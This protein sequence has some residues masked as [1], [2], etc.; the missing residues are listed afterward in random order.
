MNKKIIGAAFGVVFFAVVGAQGQTHPPVRSHRPVRQSASIQPSPLTPEME[1]RLNQIGKLDEAAAA[2]LDVGQYAKAEGYA[3]QSVSL[4]VASG[5]GQEFLAA[6]LDAQGKTQ[7]AL[8]VY[9]SIADEGDVFP[10][11]QLPYA[12]LLLKTG[13][14]EQAVAAY[15]RQ[16]PYLASGN[17]MLANSRF[18]PAVPQPRELEVAIHI[19]LGLTEGWRGYHWKSGPRDQTLAQFQQ[20]LA[21]D[22]E[23]PLA[24]YC[25]GVKLMRLG[26]QAEAQAI[27]KG[28]AE[29]TDADMKAAAEKALSGL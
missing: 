21:L 1:A 16:L 24:N 26:R 27:L 4:G 28:V 17:Q 14:W 18:S 2:A 10:R 25:Y 6:A 7:E 15:N 3:R 13:Q 9:K 29:T 8:Q 12:R 19:G 5:R 11:N 23:S 20:A 22:P